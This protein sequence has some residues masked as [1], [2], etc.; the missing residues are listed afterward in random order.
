MH[1]ILLNFVL[2]SPIISGGVRPKPPLPRTNT[3]RLPFMGRFFV[4]RIGSRVRV[5]V[6]FQQKYR[7][8]DVLRQQK[9]WVMTKGGCVRGGLTSLRLRRLTS[10]PSQTRCRRLVRTTHDGRRGDRVLDASRRPSWLCLSHFATRTVDNTVDLYAAKSDIRPESC[11][12]LPHLHS[13][14]PL[15]GSRRNIAIPFGTEKLEWCGCPT[16]EKFRRYLFDL[17]QLTNVTDTDNITRNYERTP[18]TVTKLLNQLEFELLQDRRRHLRLC[19]LFKIVSEL[20]VVPHKDIVNLAQR[21]TRG[22]HCSKFDTMR[23]NTDTLKY[24][25]FSTYTV[26]YGTGITFRKTLSLHPLYSHSKRGFASVSSSIVYMG[27]HIRE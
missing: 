24:S 3:P 25:F 13:T 18:G 11:F 27:Q 1:K 8:D 10:S 26:L 20:V 21:R 2:L 9:T 15:G 19:M 23:A 7:R 4:G 5:S 16:V 6:S 14:S 22:S 12:C 17:T